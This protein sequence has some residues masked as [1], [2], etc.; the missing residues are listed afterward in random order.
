MDN[1]V[2]MKLIIKLI[3]IKKKTIFFLGAVFTVELSQTE[4]DQADKHRKLGT[5]S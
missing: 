3:I 1:P 5:R 2:P 4:A